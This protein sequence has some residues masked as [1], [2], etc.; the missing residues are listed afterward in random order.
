MPRIVATSSGD[1]SSAGRLG[2]NSPSQRAITTV[3]GTGTAGTAVAAL[4]S[5]APVRADGHVGVVGRHVEIRAN[6]EVA[7]AFWVPLAA[8]RERASWGLGTVIVHETEEAQVPT[9]RHGDHTVWGLI[10]MLVGEILGSGQG[11]GAILALGTVAHDAVLAA[12]G[13]CAIG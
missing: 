1:T 13:G 5:L 2:S 12:S 11:L 10:G 7:E 4:T 8:I 9:F 3:D 6:R